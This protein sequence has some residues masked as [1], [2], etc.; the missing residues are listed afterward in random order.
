MFHV[1][2]RPGTH[3]C[4]ASSGE[5]SRV[6]PSAIS[7]VPLCGAARPGRRPAAARSFRRPPPC[8]GGSTSPVPHRTDPRLA[9]A[10]RAHRAPHHAP[11]RSSGRTDP[12]ARAASRPAGAEEGTTRRGGPAGRRHGRSPRRPPPIACARPDLLGP[13]PLDR[14]RSSPR[15]STHLAQDQ[16]TRRAS[17]STSTTRRSGRAR[18]NGIPG[19]PAPDADVD[20]P[21]PPAARSRRDRPHE[22]RTCRSQSR[23]PRGVRSARGR[24]PSVAS[25]RA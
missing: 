7:F 20:R 24:A 11:P 13:T 10:E 4:G 3:R 12:S 18:A 21:A 1:K 19:S 22:L 23:G 2:R 5:T 17:G 15:S 16:S 9:A 25:S 14:H 6:R 8:S